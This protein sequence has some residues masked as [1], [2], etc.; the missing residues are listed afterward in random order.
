[1]RRRR[2][3]WTPQPQPDS[4]R[5]TTGRN[6]STIFFKHPWRRQPIGSPVN[7]SFPSRV[8][9][10]WVLQLG[11]SF[12]TASAHASRHYLAIRQPLSTS[13]RALTNSLKSPGRSLVGRPKGGALGPSAS[14][15]TL[16]AAVLQYGLR[17][18]TF[19]SI[20]PAGRSR[21]RSRT[22]TMVTE[23]CR[24]P[25]CKG[26]TGTSPIP[27]SA[28]VSFPTPSIHTSASSPPPARSGVAALR[29]RPSR[30]GVTSETGRG[31]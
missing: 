3:A 17:R 6:P 1:M 5:A 23:Q 28:G 31:A 27:S 15:R 2:S 21:R 13:R 16:G 30:T 29:R 25:R 4:V 19:L 8:S 12:A 20:L 22:H 11:G 14:R 9:G 26:G 18:T 24:R 7:A 10:A